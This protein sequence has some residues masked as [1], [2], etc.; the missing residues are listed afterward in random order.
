MHK[1]HEMHLEARATSL[2]HQGWLQDSKGDFSSTLHWRALCEQVDEQQVC[3]W[4]VCW[5]VECTYRAV[6]FKFICK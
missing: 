4:K 5:A 3:G 2:G 1:G 6:N